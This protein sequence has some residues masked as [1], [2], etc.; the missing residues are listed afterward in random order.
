MWF[1]ATLYFKDNNIYIIM[2]NMTKLIFLSAIKVHCARF[3]A[4]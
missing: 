3:G 1:N 4:I 2:T